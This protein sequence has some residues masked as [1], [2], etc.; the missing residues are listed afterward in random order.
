MPSEVRLNPAR[1]ER[2]NTHMPDWESNHARFHRLNA[3]IAVH[4]G[5][6]AT[7]CRELEL[8]VAADPAEVS[9][10]VRE[11]GRHQQ[12]VAGRR[13]QNGAVVTDPDPHTAASWRF[14]E[15]SHAGN[16]GQFAGVAIFGVC[17]E[18]WL[19]A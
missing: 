16:Q 5:D 6:V 2:R 7:E 11:V 15:G 18:A 13:L 1:M 8:L 3:W 10:L 12:F 19:P 9:A 17:H 4:Q 14:G